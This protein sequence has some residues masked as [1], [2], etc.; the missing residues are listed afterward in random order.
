MC[1][2]LHSYIVV[3]IYLYT[4]K[5]VSRVGEVTQRATAM[6]EAAGN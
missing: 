6:D 1:I 3:C 2:L 4:H 5:R